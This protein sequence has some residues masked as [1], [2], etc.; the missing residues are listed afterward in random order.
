[1]PPGYSFG[2][3]GQ[4]QNMK[5]S[6]GYLQFALMLAVVM[7]YMVLAAQFESFIHPFTIMLALPLS[8]IGALGMLVLTGQTMSIFT[9]IEIIMLMGLATKNGILLVDFTNTLRAG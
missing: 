3:A 8:V 4:A 9:M 1:M 2:F 5:E 6:F 7:V